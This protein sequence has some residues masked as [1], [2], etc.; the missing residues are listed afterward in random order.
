MFVE[1]FRI[2]FFEIYS[3]DLLYKTQICKQI[4][5]KKKEKEKRKTTTT[6]TLKS[7]LCQHYEG[8][9]K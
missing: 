4:V 1:S 6:T 2:Y 5:K 9:Q 8:T 3:I 7:T